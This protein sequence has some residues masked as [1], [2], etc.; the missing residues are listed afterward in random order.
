LQF[1]QAGV[2]ALSAIR[3][4][5]LLIR[6]SRAVIK[7]Y[8]MRLEYLEDFVVLAETMNFEEAAFRLYISQ[9]TL[10][11]HIQSLEEDLNGQLFNHEN[12]RSVLTEYGKDFLDY[13]R[14]LLELHSNFMASHNETSKVPET[15]LRL[16]Y[17][18]YMKP[19]HCFEGIRK[20]S[21]SHP[22]CRIILYDSSIRELLNRGV[23]DF[24]FM[25]QMAGSSESGRSIDLGHDRFVLVVPQSHPL[26]GT[27]EV[28]IS[29]AANEPFILL[30]DRCN[31]N[32]LAKMFCMDHGF[33]P[34]TIMTLPCI[35]NILE[36]VSC[37][38]GITM[39]P[40]IAANR[41]L[42]MN[43]QIV[44]L[45]E[46]FPLT[47]SMIYNHSRNLSSQDKELA[48]YLRKETCC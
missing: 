29:E 48:E 38:Y 9:S 44:E 13:A 47:V 33:I 25:I 30:Q 20:F 41:M 24:A 22:D 3:Y 11:K 12:G 27:K 6:V 2:L 43:A 14:K 8:S 28:S 10:S 40:S 39:L 17:Q 23:L 15:I 1:H 4:Y 18:S 45:T 16:G 26:A 46:Y 32:A 35:R 42:P 37:E 34:R 19:Y 5:N 21:D 7:V 36:M 31:L